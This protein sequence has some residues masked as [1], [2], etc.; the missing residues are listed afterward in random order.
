MFQNEA[1]FDSVAPN[2]SLSTESRLVYLA[3]LETDLE[4]GEMNCSNPRAYTAKFKI[5]D[6]YNPSFNMAIEDGNMLPSTSKY[7]EISLET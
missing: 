4:N 6:Q 5:H 7:L 1:Y 3:E 2:I